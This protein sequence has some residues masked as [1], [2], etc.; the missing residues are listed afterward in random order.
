MGTVVKVA[1]GVLLALVVVIAGC[2]LVFGAF[3]NEVDKGVKKE[4]QKGALSRADAAKAKKGMT[5]RQVTRI[6]GKPRDTQE[7]DDE[8]GREEYLYYNVKGGDALT[9]WQFVFRKGKLA[10]KNRM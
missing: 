3:V 1:L 8:L 5:K 4:T 2:G 9:S 6:L 7:S 10:A